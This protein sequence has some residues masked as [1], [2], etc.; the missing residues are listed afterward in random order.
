MPVRELDTQ[1]ESHC[2]SVGQRIKIAF[3]IGFISTGKSDFHGLGGHPHK[4]WKCHGCIL[5]TVNTCTSDWQFLL[6]PVMRMQKVV[7]VENRQ[8]NQ[9]QPSLPAA[10]QLLKHSQLTSY[11]SKQEDQHVSCHHSR[12]D[13]NKMIV[14]SLE[15]VWRSSCVNRQHSW[16]VSDLLVCKSD[17]CQHREYESEKA[18]L[19]EVR[20]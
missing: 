18:L 17:C 10:N 9:V 12:E 15:F 20:M 8:F 13:I 3:R 11:L 4:E 5:R 16:L 7:K 14:K 2:Q 19:R 6:K 1:E